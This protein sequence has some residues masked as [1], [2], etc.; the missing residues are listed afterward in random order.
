MA[1]QYQLKKKRCDDCKQVRK[2]SDENHQIC[3]ICYKVGKLELSGNK[4]ID[5]FIKYTNVNRAIR[6]GNME[7]VPYDQFKNVEFIAEGG[8]SQVYKAEWIAGECQHVVLK[9]LNSSKG[10]KPKELDEVCTIFY[11]K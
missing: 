9:K 5:E 3:R 4:T 2:P 10:I 8:F 1:F 6:R 11:A 7:F